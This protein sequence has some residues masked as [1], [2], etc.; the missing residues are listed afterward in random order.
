MTVYLGEFEQLVLLAIVRLGEEASGAA[1]REAVEEGSR[2][3]VWIGAVYTT[4]QRLTDKG[5]IDARVVTPDAAGERRRKVFALTDTGQDA[6]ARAYET[7]A[8]MTRGLK[9]KLESV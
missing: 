5:L 1:I 3:T 9:P 7:W 6:I 4:L 2:R 8:R